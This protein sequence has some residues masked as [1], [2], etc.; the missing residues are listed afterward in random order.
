M[1]FY[2]TQGGDVPNY[3]NQASIL[4]IS[5]DI[6]DL[7]GDSLVPKSIGRMTLE[8]AKVLNQVDKKFIPVVA[9]KTLAII[10]QV[11]DFKITVVHFLGYTYLI[12]LL[13][14]YNEDYYLVYNMCNV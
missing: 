1:H 6:F 3:K 11:I 10:D 12:G 14:Q 2:C 8:D 4:D 13:D 7:A 5:S 9:G